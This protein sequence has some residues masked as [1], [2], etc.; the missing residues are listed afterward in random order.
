MA[1]LGAERNEE[2]VGVDKEDISIR[3]NKPFEIV[4]EEMDAFIFFK[5]VHVAYD[6]A[7]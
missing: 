3:I 5:L 2:V 1:N 6:R 7:R 4:Y